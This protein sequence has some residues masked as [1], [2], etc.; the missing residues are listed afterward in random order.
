MRW[1]LLPLAFL[2]GIALATL[3]GFLMVTGILNSIL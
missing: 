1:W 2:L 3:I